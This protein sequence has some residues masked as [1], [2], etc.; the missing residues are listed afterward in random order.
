MEKQDITIPYNAKYDYSNTPAYR[1]KLKRET[2]KKAEKAGLLANQGPLSILIVYIIDFILDLAMKIV[3]LIM[4]F[5]GYGFRFVYDGIYGDFAGIIPSSEKFGQSISMKPFRIILTVLIP[6]LG[7]FLSKGLL[8][9]FNILIC[10]IL[11][12]IHFALGVIYALVVTYTNRYAD[13]YENA[14]G[15]RI[16]MIKQ[17]VLHCTGDSDKITDI[18]HGGFGSL[19]YIAIFL[20]GFIWILWWGFRHM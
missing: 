8:G 20:I 4:D 1:R 12:Y 5:C 18:E 19:A 17:Y 15:R 6:P 10:F 9:W 3:T 7:I 2:L 14:E 11:T 16:E 13:R